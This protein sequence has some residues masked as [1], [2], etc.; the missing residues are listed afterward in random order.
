MKA[1]K[2]GLVVVVLLVITFFIWNWKTQDAGELG[3]GSATVE[4]SDR[5]VIDIEQKIDSLRVL[6]IESF[7]AGEFKKIQGRLDY[8]HSSGHLGVNPL[9]NDQKHKNLSKIL[10]AV[11]VPRVIDESIHKFNQSVWKS[12]D[13]SLIRAEIKD[14]ESNQYFD[15]TSSYVSKFDSIEDIISKYYEIHAFIRECRAYPSD[16]EYSVDDRFPLDEVVERIDRSKVYLNSSPGYGYIDN[17]TS[18]RDALKK[19]PNQ[20]YLKH[21]E[22]LK[23]QIQQNSGK[24][25]NSTLESQA[26][27]SREVYQPL[28]ASL[29]EFDNEVYEVEYNPVF[30]SDYDKLKGLLNDDNDKASEYFRKKWDEQLKQ[31]IEP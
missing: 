15:M 13:L 11:Y 28:N 29:D 25:D 26:D 14:I 1:I 22:F 5:S 6:S 31:Q 4:E 7:S 3:D 23:L 8:F 21:F 2:I 20:M 17:V 16:L 9:Q 30:S 18:I 12:S 19:I 24:Y 10:F 27:Y